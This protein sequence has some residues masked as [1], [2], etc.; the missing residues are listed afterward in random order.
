MQ[1]SVSITRSTQRR[2]SL[3]MKVQ[4]AGN[5]QVRAPNNARNLDIVDFIANNTKF[6]ARALTMP[7]EYILPQWLKSGDVIAIFGNHYIFEVTPASRARWRIDHNNKV[8][9]AS[10]KTERIE[11]KMFYMQISSTLADYIGSKAVEIAE[12]MSSLRPKKLRYKLTSSLWGS[13][14]TTGNITFNKRL[15]HYPREVIDYV[16]I[17]ELAHLQLHNHSEAFWNIVKQHCPKYNLHR[18]TLK[19]R[20][21][22]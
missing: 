4:D 3:M 15:V 16:I 17:H 6:L 1:L 19:T 9:S 7:R 10:T 11:R 18:K 22:G 12:Q 5:V 20:A 2:R 8:I 21:F 13:C 14:T